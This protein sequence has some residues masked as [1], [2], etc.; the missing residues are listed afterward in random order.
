LNVGSGSKVTVPFAFTVYVPWLATVN[1]VCEQLFG[2]CNGDT[3]HSFTVDATS[4]AVT[5]PAVSFVS[6]EMIWFVSQSPVLVSGFATGGCGMTG[7]NVLVAVWPVTSVT[8]YVIADFVPGVAFASATY[9]TTPVVGFKVYVPWFAIVTTLSAS[10]A[11]GLEDGVMRHVAFAPLVCNCV[12]VASPDVPVI[13]VKVAVPP[14]IT[15]FVS[16]V[17]TGFKMVEEF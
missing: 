4:G 2:V 17:A 7:V 12:P 6:G 3:P 9:V 11:A 8:R 16:G 15:A 10:H 13:V 1:V 14:G 5:S